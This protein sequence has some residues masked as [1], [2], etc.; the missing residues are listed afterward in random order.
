LQD[1]LIGSPK[2]TG[3][4][5]GNLYTLSKEVFGILPIPED[6]RKNVGMAEFQPSLDSKQKHHFLAH[7]QGTRKPALPIHTN[8]ERNMFRKLMRE[9]EAFEPKNGNIPNWKKAAKIWNHLADTDDDLDYK[10]SDIESL[11]T[12]LNE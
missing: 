2:I 9:N 7:M 3:W 10:V 12:L 6:I 4:I 1:V 11:I 5:N 8:A